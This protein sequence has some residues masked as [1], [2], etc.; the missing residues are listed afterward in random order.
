MNTTNPSLPAPPRPVPLVPPLARFTASGHYQQLTPFVKAFRTLFLRKPLS[1]HTFPDRTI[2]N[3]SNVPRMSLVALAQPRRQRAGRSGTPAPGGV[4][5]AQRAAPACVARLR[6]RAR[7]VS[8]AAAGWVQAGP[9]G[10]RGHLP[11]PPLPAATT[12]AV[13]G[14]PTGLRGSAPSFK[15]PPP[16][17]ILPTSTLKGHPRYQ[18]PTPCFQPTRAIEFFRY[19][20]TG[21]PGPPALLGPRL[22]AQ[23]WL[24]RAF[25]SELRRQPGPVLR[26]GPWACPCRPNL[27]DDL[28]RV[29]S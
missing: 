1:L 5:P 22:P 9:A 12:S 19:A 11:P 26:C 25:P 18:N 24:L 13:A 3:M 14:L 29:D 15:A 21:A 4:H 23:G 16:P 10:D 17:K 7:Y 28:T 2:I 6:S 20:S 27:Q 8:A